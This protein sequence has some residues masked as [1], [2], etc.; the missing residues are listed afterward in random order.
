MWNGRE[1]VVY[2][3][4]VLITGITG[5]VGSHLADYILE[6][7][8]HVEIHGLIRWRSPMD[9]IQHCKKFLQLHVGDLTDYGSLLRI[10]HEAEPDWIFHF[11]ASAF[12][13]SG[14]KAPIE[15]LRTNVIGTANL[16]EV[17]YRVGTVSR[18]LVASSSEVYGQPRPEE[19]PIKETSPFRP[20]STYAVSKVG[21]DMLA[22]QYGLS[23]D[24]DIIRTRLYT[25]TGSRRGDGYV[26]SA[27]AKQI[28]EIEAGIQNNPMRV[29]NLDSI[30]TF[31]DVR[32][33]VRAY[34][35]TMIRCS[36]GEVYNIGG[37]RTM[38]IGEM[39]QILVSFAKCPIE[40]KV[41]KSLLRPS[42]VTLQIPDV[43][44]FKAAT[45]WEPEISLEQTL[46][47][48]LNYQR[49]K[50]RDRQ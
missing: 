14:F 23:Y 19:I 8:P 31:M 47:D 27:F 38:T 40:W 3:M 45:G 6:N 17:I 7:H 43:S 46:L 16:L 12:V 32:D 22:Y 18:T 4:R 24:I 36:P 9:N 44:K 37:N 33:A 42:D 50:L 35:L 25:H 13:P 34:W 10:V 28:A 26:V 49:E 48:T 1:E 21:A 2:R 20:A 30:R 39:L 11:G 29:G 41:D 5:M 15:T